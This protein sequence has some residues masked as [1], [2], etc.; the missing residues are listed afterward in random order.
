MLHCVNQRQS[1]FALREVVPQV[2]SQRGFIGLI[3][4][5]VIHQLE[6]RSDMPAVAGQGLFDDGGG[7]AQDGGDLRAGLE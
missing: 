7:V 5:R 1:G 3:V 4:Q 6:V 2:F